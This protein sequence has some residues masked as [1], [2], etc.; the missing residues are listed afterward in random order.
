MLRHIDFQALWQIIK[1]LTLYSLLIGLIVFMSDN[2]DI[3]RSVVLINWLLVLLIIIGLRMTTRWLLSSTQFSNASNVIIYGAGSAGIQLSVA[4]KQ[5]QELNPIAFIDDN[6]TLQGRTIHGMDIISV[7]QLKVFS[8]TNHIEEV[9]LALPSITRKRRNEII[10]DLQVF[11]LLVRSVPGISELVL[12]KIQIE[13]LQDIQIKDLLGRDS[14]APID[15]LL[16]KN[17]LGKVVMVTGAGGSIGSELCRQIVLLKPK[18]LIMFDHSEFLLYS[19]DSELSSITSGKIKLIPMLGTVNNAARLKQI[20]NKFKVDTIYHAAAYKHVP[21]VEFNSTEGVVNNVFGTLICAKAAIDAN[22]KT[23]V[24]ISTDKAVRPTN[25]MGA[26]KR[27]AELILQALSKI[28]SQTKFTIVRFGNVLGSSGS[29]VPVFNKQIKEGGPITVTDQKMVRYFMTIPE[30][31]ELVIQSGSMGKGGDVFVLDMGEPISIDFLARR[32]IQLSGFKI[33]DSMNKNGDIEIV[34]TGLRPG[35]KLFEEL[36]IGDNISQTEHSM[37][38]CAQEEMIEWSELQLIMDDLM[39]A[40]ENS[41]FEALRNTLQKTIP[42]YKPQGR[43]VDFLH[44]N[45]SKLINR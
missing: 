20:F 27:L 42:G 36:L 41:D 29:V 26:T 44:V 6:I 15:L 11:S 32:M 38:L 24:L 9:L 21:M 40:V 12:G 7:D 35:E 30:A 5:S 37:I 31:V 17:I 34:Y 8:R 4:L 18:I 28:Q 23:F 39:S 13:D 10:T 16:K 2:E 45:K 33:K 25:T 19:I 1:A 3:P 14:V 43:V 22:V